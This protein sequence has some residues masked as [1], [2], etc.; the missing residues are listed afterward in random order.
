LVLVFGI[1]ALVDGVLAIWT[2]IE[3]RKLSE[4][5]WVL[6]LFGLAGIGAGILTFMEPGITAIVLLFYIAA[7]A[8]VRGVLEISA[9]IR[10][11]KEIDN[12]WLLI[13]AGLASVVFGVLLMYSP[14][15]GMLA[16][17]WLLAAYAIIYGV[18][19]LVLAFRAR[20]F[21]KQV[22]GGAAAAKAS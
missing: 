8:I 11:R 7:W 10:L 4:H 6:L 15:A 18:I 21:A 3:G 2:A 16:V 5:W 1:Y 22:T 12:E 13:L 20:S 17:L 9:G 14:G 19:L